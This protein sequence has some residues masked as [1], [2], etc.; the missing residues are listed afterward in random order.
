MQSY[1]E[2]WQLYFIKILLR[3]FQYDIMLYWNNRAI[4]FFPMF[5]NVY[6][7]CIQGTICIIN[8]I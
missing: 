6:L 3:Y 8:K 7:E 5:S 4:L 1:P 2:G